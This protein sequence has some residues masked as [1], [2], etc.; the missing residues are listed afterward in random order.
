MVT[1]HLPPTYSVA[2][3]SLHRLAEHVVSPALYAATGKIGLRQSPGGIAT[4]P[5]GDTARVIAID[6]DHLVVTDQN[7]SRR[8][9]ITTIADAAR[10][11]GITPGAPSELYNPNT[12]LEPDS[13]LTADRDAVEV[14]AMWYE[15]T[16]M[17]L[18]AFATSIADDAPSEAQLWPEH[19][20]LA[21]AADNINYG[22]SPGDDYIDVPYLYVGPFEGRPTEPD[23]FWN[24]PFGAAIGFDEIAS[25]Q[26]AFDFFR[27]GRE[28]TKASR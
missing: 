20:D 1:R 9:P 5:F 10:F 15:L 26:D 4:P 8:T 23:P 3:E 13:P 17:A 6:L 28:L 7:G 19:F 14:L 12:P 22:G 16:N 18:R 27:R 2:R 11:V 21:L 25:I 24:Q